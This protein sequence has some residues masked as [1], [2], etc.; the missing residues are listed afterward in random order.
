MGR[1]QALGCV[2]CSQC[3]GYADTPALVHHVR[4]RHGWGR[5]SHYATIPL[6]PVHHENSGYGVHDMGREQ[7]TEMYGMSEIE[8]LTIVNQKLEIPS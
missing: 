3:L 6:C 2:V 4:V 5:S 8:L 7:F 1:V